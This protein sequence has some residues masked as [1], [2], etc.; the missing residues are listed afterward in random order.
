MT[1]AVADIID[2]KI[3]DVLRFKQR[4]LYYFCIVNILSL[5]NICSTKIFFIAF[6]SIKPFKDTS[7]LAR[8]VSLWDEVSCTVQNVN[9][10]G[11]EH[12]RIL[13]LYIC[14][15]Q[16]N[17]HI[18]SIQSKINHH[19]KEKSFKNRN[20]RKMLQLV[21]VA[22]EHDFF[23]VAFLFIIYF[24]AS[25]SASLQSNVVYCKHGLVLCLCHPEYR[26]SIH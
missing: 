21:M 23:T 15:M 10:Y 20:S 12:A 4:L 1:T 19:K 6:D 8:S 11:E 9:F 2:A 3:I 13:Q 18:K 7:D 5:E 17:M 14:A 22:H 25:S 26:F 24:Q 16:K